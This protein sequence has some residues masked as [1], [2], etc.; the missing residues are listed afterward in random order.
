MIKIDDSIRNNSVCSKVSDAFKQTRLKM[1][2]QRISR[3]EQ[4]Q[5]VQCGKAGLS[6][7]TRFTNVCVRKD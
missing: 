2:P 5:Y 6:N 7:R 1:L 3:Y 4:Y